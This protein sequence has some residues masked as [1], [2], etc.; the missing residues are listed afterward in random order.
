MSNKP[1]VKITV[2]ALA[3]RVKWT[4]LVDTGWDEGTLLEIVQRYC[5]AQDHAKNYRQRAAAKR[6]LLTER[7][8]QLAKASGM[9]VE[10]YLEA[11]T[12]TLGEDEPQE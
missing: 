3:L 7:L 11:E 2:P 10:Q 5:D 1:T 6:K 8:E 9:T 12:V 4:S